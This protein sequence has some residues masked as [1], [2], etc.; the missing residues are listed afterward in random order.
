[1]I[2]H[3]GLVAWRRG[4][5]WRGVLIQGPSG[6]GKSDLA[7]RAVDGGACLVADD[8]VLLWKS[9]DRLYGRAPDALCGLTEVRGVEVM[10][11]SHIRY[12]E[13]ALS[14]RCE[15]GQAEIARLY[16]GEEDEVLGVSLPCVRLHP[17]EASAPAKLRRA[18]DRL[19]RAARPS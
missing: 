19:G 12:A 10:G 1:M 9:G 11:C 4:G 17:C 5:L 2:L 18:F 6:V 8:R 7:L 3:G 15:A 16:D 13:V 14:V